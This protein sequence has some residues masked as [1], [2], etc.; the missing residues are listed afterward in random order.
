[1]IWFWLVSVVVVLPSAAM[2]IMWW[3]EN[4]WR[5]MARLFGWHY[6]HMK[7]TATEIVRRVHQTRAGERYVVYFGEH[8]VFIDRANCGWSVTALTEPRTVEVV[9]V[10]RLD[11]RRR[12]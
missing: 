4:G 1:M 12:A 9:S 6:V 2:A 7:N 5:V 8:L 10:T 3:S 11:D